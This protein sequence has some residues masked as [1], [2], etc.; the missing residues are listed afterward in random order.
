[1][2]VL[3]LNKNVWTNDNMKRENLR[4]PYGSRDISSVYTRVYLPFLFV[5]SLGSHI[6]YPTNHLLILLV[7]LF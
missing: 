2:L 3:V 5:G 7:V 6:F 4:T 1:M